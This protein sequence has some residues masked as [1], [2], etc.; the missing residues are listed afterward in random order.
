MDLSEEFRIPF[1]LRPAIS[2]CH[3]RQ[4][5]SWDKLKSN[6]QKASFEKNPGRWAA[7]PNSALSSTES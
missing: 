6:T 7:T 1:I 4:N 5:L 3:A 2:V